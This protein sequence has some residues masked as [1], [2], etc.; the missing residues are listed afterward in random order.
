MNTEDAATATR[1][2]RFVI[3]RTWRL[4]LCCDDLSSITETTSDSALAVKRSLS[5][6]I[7]HGTALKVT[8][9]ILPIRDM[10]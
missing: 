6:L 4:R 8:E 5:L 9:L 1:V 7:T 2:D 3:R 10:N